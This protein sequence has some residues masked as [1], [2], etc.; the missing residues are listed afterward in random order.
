VAK[1]SRQQP[2]PDS[3]TSVSGRRTTRRRPVRHERREGLLERYRGVLLG[4]V[5]LVG[6]LIIGALAFQGTTRAAYE[7]IS[8]LTPGPDETLPPE[9]PTPTP[10]PTA[11]PSPTPTQGASPSATPTP[12]PNATPGP[13]PSPSPSPSPQPTP[14]PDPTPRS[15]FSTTNLGRSHITDPNRTIRYGFCPPTSGDHFNVAN[16]A[17]LPA[18]V[19]PVTAERGP[20]AWVHNLEHGSVILLYRCPSGQLGVGDCISQAEMAQVQQ[21]FEQAPDPPV[22]TCPT[23]VLAARFDAMTTRFALVGW[24]RAL[25]FDEFDMDAAMTFTEQWMEHDAVPEAP[26]C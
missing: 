14:A 12:D 9:R 5:V 4:G 6:V 18:A 17:P 10:S 20:G 2:A 26:A 19:Y 11:S 25:L 3:V 1:R 24:N 7:C 13:S 8:L 21:W 22:S 23:K 16:L 15:G